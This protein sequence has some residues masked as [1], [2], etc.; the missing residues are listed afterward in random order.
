MGSP[1]RKDE[2]G[3]IA[4]E[5]ALIL[6]PLVVLVFGIIEFGR[7]FSVYQVYQGAVRE[8]GRYAAVR[9]AAGASPSLAD[10]QSRVDEAAEPYAADLDE[11]QIT[12]TN[13]CTAA[14]AGEPVTVSWTQSFEI[15]IP[16]VPTITLD[17]KLFESSFR[18]E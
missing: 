10:I 17:D 5:F 1:F 15:N 2:N 16:M 3:A 12:V 11:T 9:T 14:T 13:P 8:G 6:I 4:V 7:F 18:C